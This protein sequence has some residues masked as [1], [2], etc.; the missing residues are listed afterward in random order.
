[1]QRGP[2]GG[3]V[4]DFVFRKSPADAAG[5]RSG[6][7]LVTIDGLALDQPADLVSHVRRRKPGMTVELVVRS[8]GRERTIGV[9]LARHPGSEQVA[10]LMHVG[11]PAPD[12]S[13]VLAVRG[14]VPTTMKKLRGE[15]VLVDFFASWCASCKAL[16]PT[17]AAWHRRYRSRGLRVVGITA[18]P[19]ERASRT[20]EAWKIPYAVASDP[21]DRANLAY[22][23]SALPAVFVVDRKGVIRDVMIGY[24]PSRFAAFEKHVEKLLAQP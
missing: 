24:D 23:V 18:D 11:V 9:Q 12:L 20:V 13:H 15:V 22:R 16:T 14:T 1:M 5:I 19:P 10:R 4:V 21:S 2:A 17:L 6:D 3:V 7:K 8:G